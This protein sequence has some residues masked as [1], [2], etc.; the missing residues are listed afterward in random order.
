MHPH[1]WELLDWTAVYQLKCQYSTENNTGLWTAV[2]Q[3]KCQYQYWGQYR[4][5]NYCVSTQVSVSVLRTIQNYELLCINSSVNNSTED[6]TGLWTAVNQLKCQ[7][8][9]WGQ[10][11]TMNR[12]VST[13]VSV[14]VLRTIQ[15]YELLCI[16]SSVSISTEDNTGLWTAVY[17]L[18]CQYQYWGQYRTMNCCVSTQLSV[19]VLR[20]IQDY[21]LLCINSTVSISTEDNIGL[22]TAKFII[23]TSFR[24]LPRLQ[25]IFQKCVCH[26][27]LC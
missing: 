4:I 10:Y 5:M 17:Q 21:E 16:N 2:Y 13:Q 8:Q 15:D 23:I 12:C 26:R 19:S 22:W 3:L 20:T 25:K 9:Y 11:R 7:S 18:K 1:N 24:F 6:N 14:S 27:Q